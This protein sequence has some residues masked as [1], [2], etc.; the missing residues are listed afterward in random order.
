MDRQALE[1]AVRGE[2]EA[3]IVSAVDCAGGD[4]RGARLGGGVFHRVSFRGADLSGAWCREAQF[5]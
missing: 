5:M 3:P 4:Y 2:G 1:A